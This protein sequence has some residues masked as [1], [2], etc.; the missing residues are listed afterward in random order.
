PPT[1][2]DAV[3]VDD[4]LRELR[5]TISNDGVSATNLYLFHDGEPVFY[6]S[7]GEWQAEGATHGLRAWA[8]FGLN[9]DALG[10]TKWL[11]GQSV[12][13]APGEA[14]AIRS[15]ARMLREELLVVAEPRTCDFNK[16]LRAGTMLVTVIVPVSDGCDAGTLRLYARTAKGSSLHEFD[17]AGRVDAAWLR[18]F[19]R[20]GNV[21]LLVALA[22][23]N[24]GGESLRGWRIEDGRF[25]EISFGELTPAQQASFGG[26][27]RYRVEG[28]RLLRRYRAADPARGSI[29]LVYNWSNSRWLAEAVKPRDTLQENISGDWQGDFAMEI[30][31]RGNIIVNAACGK[32]AFPVIS[33]PGEL[34]LVAAPQEA[35]MACDDASLPLDTGTWLAETNGELLRLT[36]LDGG[37]ILEFQPGEATAAD[38][39]PV[40]GGSPGD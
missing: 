6:R 7:R 19:D 21:E 9:G 22:S 30:P 5:E 24:N 16:S 32:V 25:T 3:F 27:N 18:D 38:E 36:P 10:I 29:R 8:E 20:D 39:K 11:D 12:P 33:L 26:A 2:V 23:A 13:V 15:R 28:E 1:T 34:L 4:Q 31:E 37:Q 40:Q 35:P 14:N 17:R